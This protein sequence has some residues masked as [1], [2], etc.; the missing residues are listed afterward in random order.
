MTG[1]IKTKFNEWTKGL[2]PIKAR[3]SIFEHIRDIPYHIDPALFDLETGPAKM[4]EINMGSCTPKHYLMGMMFENL[5]L[6]VRYC[7]YPFNWKDLGA[8][9]PEE[10]ARQAEKIPVTYHLACKALLDGKWVLVDATWDTLLAGTG[11]PVNLE[12]NGLNDTRL[13]VVPA[14]ETCYFDAAS[15]ANDAEKVME[16]YSLPEKLELSRFS[17][18][19]NAWMG[20][21]RSKK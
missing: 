5:G 21:I 11:F 17:A 3:I 14:G 2:D 8:G 1:I 12:W 10:L 13:A 9:Y 6:K 20:F 15:R 16:E 7:T 4:L 18:S 19:L